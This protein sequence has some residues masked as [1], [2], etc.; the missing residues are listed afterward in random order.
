[1]RRVL[2]SS[3][4]REP[5]PFERATLFGWMLAVGI[6]IDRQRRWRCEGQRLPQ[7]TSMQ[8]DSE[9]GR[10]VLTTHIMPKIP[11]EIVTEYFGYLKADA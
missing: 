1:M 6:G 8:Y 10:W 9:L 4:R 3:S 5:T 11:M 7:T 2:L